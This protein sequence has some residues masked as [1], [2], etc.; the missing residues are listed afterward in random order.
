MKRDRYKVIINP[1]AGKGRAGTLL[2][3]VENSLKRLNLDFEIF[4]TERVW[5]AAELASEAGREGFTVVVA[6]GGD[7]T[8]N[9]VINGLMTAKGRGEKIPA[10]AVLSI[11]RGNDFSFGADIPS[12]LPDCL[13]VLNNGKRRLLDVGLIKGGL[14]Q[15]AYFGNGIGIG[16]DTIWV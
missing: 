3:E 15:R 6:G 2:P 7:G 14:T 10:L 12:N 16:F 13:E 1:T 8:V 5:H 4:T 11:G 9:E